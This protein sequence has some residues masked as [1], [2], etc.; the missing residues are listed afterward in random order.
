[1]EQL[2]VF[3]TE[4]DDLQVEYEV[5]AD[6]S[7]IQNL[8]KREYMLAA[9]EIDDQI[10]VCLDK[11][12]E[13]NTDIDRLTNHADGLDYAVAVA[14]GILT[15]LIDSFFVGDYNPNIEDIV[16]EF[17]KRKAKGSG[18]DIDNY[19]DARKWLEGNYH[20]DHDGAYKTGRTP[21]T[22][23]TSGSNGHTHRLD[24]L[25]HHPTLLGLVASIFFQFFRVAFFVNNEGKVRPVV[26]KE[27][28]KELIKM[29]APAVLSGVLAWV[30]NVAEQYCEEDLGKDIPEPMKKVIKLVAASPM[31]IQV[32][33]CAER[34][35]GHIMS[36]VGPRID[37]KEGKGI[38][39]I[40]LSLLKEIAILVPSPKLHTA[41]QEM[42]K[43]GSMNFD[44]ELEI[45]YKLKQQAMPVIINEV[46]VRTFYFIR[47]LV[48]EYKE[49]NN[50]VDI[51]WQQ[52]IPFGNRT[53]ERMMTI[54]SGT[55]TAVDLAD[56][57]IRSGGV[58][59]ACLLRVNFV[60]IGRF[61][62]AVVTDVS[63]GIKRNKLRNERMAIYSEMLALT[64]AKIF[65]MEAGM[66]CSAIDTGETL[67]KTA[68]IA[69]ASVAYF[70]TAWRD[71]TEDMEVINPKV[72][73]IREKV[74]DFA[75]NLLDII[76]LG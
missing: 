30:S 42:Y 36:D 61:A 23:Q 52:V 60:G 58:N 74:P 6:P 57:A 1:M 50:F 38:P 73:T 47:R 4:A 63:M 2:T 34:W 51:N 39:G 21:V 69:E 70:V 28:I 37:G 62:I 29:W 33:R 56:A 66:W 64:N 32:F 72:R 3:K 35:Y 45:V 48:S 49:H 11:V 43:N 13:L 59:P 5:L 15:G 17:A 41:I 18:T 24:D 27:D 55:F 31:I 68:Q 22:N 75:D 20:V 26:V 76:T 7:Q 10:K 9:Q 25:A 12:A 8:R 44:K 46:I 65:Y 40:F 16:T 71:T 19:E 14:S 54:A 67:L 53:V